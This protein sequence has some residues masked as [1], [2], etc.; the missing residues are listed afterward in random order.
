MTR[1]Q[2]DT[3]SLS[4]DPAE[5]RREIE[6]LQ[7]ELAVARASSAMTTGLGME[8][9]DVSFA[10][11]IDFNDDLEVS[12]AA[13]SAPTAEPSAA[14]T[15]AL[16]DAHKD[17][18]RL[19]SDLRTAEARTDRAISQAETATAEAAR[20][21]RLLEQHKAAT[22]DRMATAE[23]ACAEHASLT[24]RLAEAEQA[25]ATTETARAAAAQLA[26]TWAERARARV[27]ELN[28]LQKVAV[29]AQ[30]AAAAA[31]DRAAAAE[32]AARDALTVLGQMTD[33]MEKNIYG[34]NTRVEALSRRVSSLS[35]AVGAA[36]RQLSMCVESASAGLR[37]AKAARTA[38]VEA[39]AADRQAAMAAKRSS[40]ALSDALQRTVSAARV[41]RDDLASALASRLQLELHHAVAGQTYA[42]SCADLPVA[43]RIERQSVAIGFLALHLAL[44]SAAGGPGLA[45]GHLSPR[46][47]PGG[48]VDPGMSPP[49][50]LRPD[51]DACGVLMPLRQPTPSSSEATAQLVASMARSSAHLMTAADAA[52]VLAPRRRSLER[53][54]RLF[55]AL[56]DSAVA[57]NAALGAD[58]LQLRMMND[59]LQRHLDDAHALS[60]SLVERI[61]LLV[62]DKAHAAADRIDANPDGSD[63][64]V[65]NIC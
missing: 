2:S 56:L 11:P 39:A 21:S 26:D 34:A 61:R 41:E 24:A 33:A 49:C 47:R 15:R 18:A 45:A 10:S 59:V 12:F 35:F 30:A 37:T 6:R 48:P 1:E 40:A 42:R 57:D 19:R 13:T 28:E 54:I 23:K 38:A 36:Q 4:E 16:A 31:D 50:A 20:L 52:N 22:A 58:N 43:E 64:F 7:G 8:M 29:G 60:D 25:R 62:D 44:A 53:D 27:D 5:L 65:V 3:L 32:T 17:L 55:R 63:E 51:D 46:G 9:V 14:E